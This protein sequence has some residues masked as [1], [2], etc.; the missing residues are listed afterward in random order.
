MH[1]AVTAVGADRP[2]IAAAV[3]KV[4]YEHGGNI[5]D[6]RMAI[7]GG[8]FAMMLIVAL[9]SGSDAGAMER[10][11]SAAVA[12][13][14]LI[15]AVR[16]VAEVPPED[17]RGA[18]YVVSVY[19]ADRPG[20]VFRVCD[21]LA[22]HRVNVTDLATRVVEGDPPVYVMILEATVP[23][24]IDPGMVERDL[25]AIGSELSVDVAFNPLEAETL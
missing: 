22:G 12:S 1:V 4:L 9:P 21:A 24:G 18:G 11:L 8:H 23:A 3:T 10:S 5:E 16:P 13:L 20:I 25:K 7:L 17:A 19:G 6:S 14:D 2:G 15:V